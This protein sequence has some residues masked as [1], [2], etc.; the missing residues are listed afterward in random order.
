MS[1]QI[2]YAWGIR[3]GVSTLVSSGSLLAVAALA[4]SRV[5]DRAASARLVD[6]TFV[7]DNGLLLSTCFLGG[8]SHGGG[9]S[10]GCGGAASGCRGRSGSGGGGG[11]RG[12]RRGWISSRRCGGISSRRSSR[13]SGRR[14][15]RIS[16]CPGR[17]NKG[18]DGEENNYLRSH[19]GLYVV[20]CLM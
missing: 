16:H 4:S 6:L 20:L 12:R 13:I 10:G 8:G 1:G 11:G 17:R 2:C 3:N 19:L 7:V 5:A 18:H 9:C 15:G 14:S